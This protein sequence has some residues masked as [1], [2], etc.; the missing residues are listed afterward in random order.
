M[1]EGIEMTIDNLYGEL[2]SACRAGGSSCLT[3]RTE[4]TPAGGPEAAVAP[5]KFAAAH[6]KEGVYAYEQRF[7][8][9][10]KRTTVLIDSKQSQLNRA[11]AALVQAI[12]DGHS[13]LARLP[14][15]EVI[16]ERDG[17]EECYLDLTLPHR[18]F[19]GH[20]RAGTVGDV[21]T[22]NTDEYRAL[23]DASPVNARAL[24]E[25]SPATLVF[26]GWDSTRASHQG[27]WRSL[28]VGEIIGVCADGEPAKKG[29]ARVDP[30]GMS[31][32]LSGDVLT[33]LANDQKDELSK[34]NY[35]GIVKAAKKAKADGVSAS[36][37]GL[38][39]IPPT[40]SALGGVACERIIRT[41]VFSFAAL[42]Q[43]RFGG[44]SEQD[45][46]CRALLA[47][48]ALNALARSD[49]EI[50]LRANCDLVE[51][52]KTTVTLD[53]RQ[54]ESEE[55]SALSIAEADQLLAVALN[56][57][58]EL[59]GIEWN[60]VVLTVKGNPEIVAGAVDEDTEENK[61]S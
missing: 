41:H 5:A 14:R 42:R 60:G 50:S 8:D 54:G 34:N 38:G 31:V 1:E 39:G 16:Y 58:K 29:G 47:A 2:R 51:A 28:L 17:K 7:I 23:R 33:R 18:A 45:V 53:L 59:A 15:I 32:K 56:N 20:I 9:G 35:D 4:L 25:A 52:G 61:E 46:V 37:L 22:T 55:L 3:S 19:D 24:L 40:L 30:V 43:I 13:V 11:E 44:S 26:G 48:L 12:A 36:A 21:P 6:G 49:A 57:A 27:R 10:V